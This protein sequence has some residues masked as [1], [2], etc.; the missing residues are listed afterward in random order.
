MIEVT[1]S[2][3]SKVTVEQFPKLMESDE[4]IVLF[5]KP[6]EGVVLKPNTIHRMGDYSKGWDMNQFTDYNKPVT[7][8][9]K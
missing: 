2:E 5:N 1:L 9:N 3:E 7:L 6:E 4:L 8:Q